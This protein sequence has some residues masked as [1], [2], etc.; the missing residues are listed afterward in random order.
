MIS[1]I[2]QRRQEHEVVTL[3]GNHDLF[4][5]LFLSNFETFHDW[6]LFGGIDTLMS[7]SVRPSLHMKKQAIK[8]LADEFA[9][10]LPPEHESFFRNLVPSFCCGDYFFS[11]AG[12]KPGTPLEQQSEDDLLWI[13]D[14]FIEFEGTFAKIIVHGHTPA[15]AVEQKPNRINVDTGAYATGVLSTVVLEGT[16]IRVLDT[17]KQT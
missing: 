11:H 9:A 12:V 16:S 7:Y 1:L 17:S 15:A 10:V 8:E 3:K 13:R 5:L 6:R 14:E 2:L 4:P